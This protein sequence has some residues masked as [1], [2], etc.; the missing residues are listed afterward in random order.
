MLISG[1]AISDIHAQQNPSASFDLSD[2]DFLESVGGRLHTGGAILR[3]R[4]KLDESTYCFTYTKTSS[5]LEEDFTIGFPPKSTTGIPTPVLVLWHQW[6]A[7]DSKPYYQTKFFGEGRV[8][9]WY[10]ISPLGGHRK[11]WGVQWSQENIKELLVFLRTF[12]GLLNNYP[13]MDETRVYGVGFSMGGGAG[14]AYASRHLDPAHLRISAFANHTGTMSVAREWDPGNPILNNPRMFGSPYKN[15]FGYINQAIISL[16]PW[17]PNTVAPGTDLYRNIPTIPIR[18]TRAIGDN[19]EG[20]TQC[21]ILDGWATANGYP[22]TYVSNLPPVPGFPA[23]CWATLDANTTCN[24]LASQPT[25][26]APVGSIRVLA[27]NFERNTGSQRCYNI[28]VT[29]NNGQAM[30][31]FE[32][33]NTIVLTLNTL[34]LTSSP[35]ASAFDI[36]TLDMGLDPTNATGTLTLDLSGPVG[37]PAPVTLKVHNILPTMTTATRTPAH[38]GSSATLS[39]AGVMTIV[40][41]DPGSNPTWTIP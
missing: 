22:H 12:I 35:A 5:G 23:H 8:R 21:A 3:W 15:P 11:H 10:V 14:A 40:E 37:P 27:D 38:P 41:P 18:T 30:V 29:P 4:G 32:Y 2:G 19:A 24:W 26:N 36:H 20:A 31:R 16:W 6:G 13:P 1:I 7:S 17:S 28:S 34:S 33:D 39:P 9:G 25:F